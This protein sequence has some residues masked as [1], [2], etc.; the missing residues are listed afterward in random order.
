MSQK[1]TAP[2]PPVPEELAAPDEP[3]AVPVVDASAMG[4]G[5]AEAELVGVPEDGAV[6][7]D[8]DAFPGAD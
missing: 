2:P 6:G 7:V 4:A 1:P 8:W 3:A 5:A